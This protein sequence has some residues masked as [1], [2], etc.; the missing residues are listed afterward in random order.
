MSNDVL[1]TPASRKIEFKDSSGNVDAV[2]QTDSSGNLSITNTGGDLSLGDTTSDI[3]VGDGT[4]NVD[5]VFEQ[6]GE[7]RGTSGVTV[8]LG[9]SGATTNLAGT[10]QLGGT[11]ITST[12]AELNILDGVTATATEINKL[13]GVTATTAEL[14]HVDGV[15]SAIQTQLDA[16]ASTS[17]ATTSA[18]GLMSS[19]DK[20]KLDG[21]ASSATANPNAIDN[22]V[23]DTTP[24]LGGDLDVNSKNLKIGLS[25]TSFLS[26][27]SGD[28]I[29][30]QNSGTTFGQ[31]YG[32]TAFG[33][34]ILY[35]ENTA[36]TTGMI[37]HETDFQHHFYIGSASKFYVNSSGVT[38]TGNIAVSGTVD[39]K[40][41]STL[42]AGVV[43]DTTPQLG[44]DLDANGNDIKLDA[45]EKIYFGDSDDPD[46]NWIGYNTAN[47]NLQFQATSSNGGWEFDPQNGGTY[48]FK[49]SAPSGAG[50]WA[51]DVLG[52][53]TGG[54]ITTNYSNSSNPVYFQ[55]NG[56]TKISFLNTGAVRLANLDINGAYTLPTSDG[57]NGQVLTTDGSGA[58]TFQDGGGGFPSGT[59]MLF[60]QTAAPTGWTKQTTHNDK[61][62]RV[63]SGTAGTGGSSAFT[64]A[65]ATPSVSGSVGLSGDLAAGNLAVSMSGSI[66]NTTLSTNQIPSHTHSLTPRRFSSDAN[67]NTRGS[68]APNGISGNINIGTSGATGG[69]QAHNH[70]HNLSGTLTGTPG[71]GNLAGSLS[72]ATAT[73]NVQY[74]DLI[75]AAKD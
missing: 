21:V 57:T 10:V 59:L 58:V 37:V 66:S 39:G 28:K 44:G 72:S 53:S 41:V 32:G 38:V 52:N 51:I 2:I 15:T 47:N 56:T 20:T 24:Q 3:F 17:A 26:G 6:N 22:V 73:I 46:A 9:A 54:T 7:I 4:N 5:I 64:T 11:T 48:N 25:S 30:F 75:I 31:I 60:Q 27:G 50:G 23:E 40:D 67:N 14:N 19:S 13:D 70:A 49:L 18:N 42:I 55:K 8:T 74:V 36:S 45:N 71:T 62:L 16:K 12:G 65:F 43:N 29:E 69:G 61:A 68:S 33:Y 35:L 1:I 63:V 34:P